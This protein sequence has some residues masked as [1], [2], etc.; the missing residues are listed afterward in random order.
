MF[1][2][3]CYQSFSLPTFNIFYSFGF[4]QFD[5][6]IR[7][8][9]YSDLFGVLCFKSVS[10][11]PFVYLPLLPLLYT[12]NIFFFF[13]PWKKFCTFCFTLFSLF[14]MLDAIF[15]L[16]KIL[17]CVCLCTCAQ[18]SLKEVDSSFTIEPKDWPRVIRL[19]S[20]CFIHWAHLSTPVLLLL[21]CVYSVIFCIELLVWSIS[22]PGLLIFLEFPLVFFY[23]LV[24]SAR[25]SYP[26]VVVLK[27]DQDNL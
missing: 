16:F 24:F 3:L 5:Y 23:I 19:D 17:I 20:K 18:K 11:L 25:I 1:I 10:A 2:I 7:T 4:Q 13:V 12:L 6:D 9:L 26:V 22:F 14:F 8:F 15:N 21:C 27:H